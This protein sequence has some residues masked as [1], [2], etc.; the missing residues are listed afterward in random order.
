MRL[1]W[2]ALNE[3][4]SIDAVSSLAST[5]QLRRTLAPQQEELFDHFVSTSEQCRWN[6]DAN[7]FGGLEV[8]GQRE[9]RWLLDRQVGGLRSLQNSINERSPRPVPDECLVREH[10]AAD[11]LRV[12]AR[13]ALSNSW[14]TSE[15]PA[16]EILSEA[17]TS[18]VGQPEK[19]GSP[20]GRSA[21]PPTPDMS[22]QRNN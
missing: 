13:K 21:L 19:S 6:G 22:L 20:I 4:H 18:G 7:C 3:S 2:L 16:D 14:K 5:L 12:Q 11:T 15:K 9:F 8:D 17:A 10:N 1:A